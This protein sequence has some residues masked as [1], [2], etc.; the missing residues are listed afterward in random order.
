ML[1]LQAYDQPLI[2]VGSASSL[3]FR[4]V[5]AKFLVRHTFRQ[6]PASAE[7]ITLITGQPLNVKTSG[8]VSN[9]KKRLEV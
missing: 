1:I 9:C 6:M 8:L 7:R 3:A 4:S 2:E 5:Q